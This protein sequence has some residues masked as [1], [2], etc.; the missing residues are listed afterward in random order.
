[1]RLLELGRHSEDLISEGS[2]RPRIL[3]IEPRAQLPLLAPGEA[4]DR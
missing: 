2:R 3:T 1:M 4:L